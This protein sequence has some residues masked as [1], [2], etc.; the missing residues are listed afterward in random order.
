MVVNLLIRWGPPPPEPLTGCK[1]LEI[2]DES[3]EQLLG[4]KFH[5]F[6]RGFW[7]M[8]S[9]DNDN[10]GRIMISSYSHFEYAENTL[11]PDFSPQ[12]C[13]IIASAVAGE[14]GSIIVIDPRD[15]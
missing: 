8:I 2:T 7:N 9:N 6:I 14:N 3:Y 11:E 13:R 10:V 4:E 1:T 5:E 15:L 12:N